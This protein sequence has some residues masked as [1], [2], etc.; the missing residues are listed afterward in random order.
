LFLGSN[1]GNL[2]DDEASE[3][4]SKLDN[5]LNPQDKIVLGLDLIKAEEIVLPA[6]NDPHNITSKFNLNLLERMNRELKAEFDINQFEHQPEYTEK[7]GIAKSFLVSVATHSVNIKA[8]NKTVTFNK[9]EKIHTEIS[10]KYNDQVLS[11]II[12][13]TRFTISDKLTDSKDYF[14]DYFLTKS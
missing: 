8:L 11:E 3:F 14:A 5:S 4:L 2:Q 10:R 1:M 6:Y 7:E 9:G 12:E 13:S